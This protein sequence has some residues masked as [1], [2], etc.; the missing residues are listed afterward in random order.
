LTTNG[1]VD[2]KA[3]PD[4]D[5]LGLSS[6]VEY[7]APRNNTEERLLLIWQDILGREQIGVK[8]NFFDL[9]GHSLKA[10]RIISQIKKQFKLELNIKE[11]FYAPTIEGVAAN[12]DSILWLQ[13]DKAAQTEHTTDQETLIF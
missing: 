4:P 2:K 6:G 5:G 12:I 7:L 10:V 1:K 13:E 3:L 11:L 8:D 9:G